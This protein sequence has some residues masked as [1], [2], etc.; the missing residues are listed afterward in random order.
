M[1]L[2]AENYRQHGSILG[3]NEIMSMMFHRDVMLLGISDGIMCAATGFGLILQKLIYKG[4][5]S[6]NR[7]GWI[8]QVVSQ[9]YFMVLFWIF[10]YFKYMQDGIVPNLNRALG[11]RKVGTVKAPA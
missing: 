10:I 2:F 1:R 8:I 11:V 6:W 9:L 7:E 3:S 5:F 4:Y